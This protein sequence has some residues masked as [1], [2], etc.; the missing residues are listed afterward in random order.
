LVI[1]WQRLREICDRVGAK[2]HADI[3]HIAGMIAV[4]LFP[5]PAPYA[6]VITTT[7]HKSLRGPRGGMIMVP[8]D[9]DLAK[10]INQAIFPGLQGG[11]LMQVIAAK[12]VAFHEA[13]QPGFYDYQK[14]VLNNAK[15]M[16][17]EFQKLGYKITSNATDTHLFLVDLTEKGLTGKDAETAL[18]AIGIVLN[19][20]TVPNDTRSP[21]ITSGV[22]IGT[23]GITTRGMDEA[24][25]RHLTRM[26]DQCWKSVGDQAKQKQL[27]EQVQALCHQFQIYN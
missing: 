20:N 18:D 3:A 7:T 26:I 25:V 15:A 22:R 27:A 10:K 17:D 13:L 14:M 16:C 23:C 24:A 21:F 2:L 8:S 5:S 11:P 12:A 4:G 19:K 6:D 9:E 1:D